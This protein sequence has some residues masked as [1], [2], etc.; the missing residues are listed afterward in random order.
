MPVINLADVVGLETGRIGIASA[1]HLVLLLHGFQHIPEDY[2]TRFIN[3]NKLADG[4]FPI[5]KILD[6]FKDQIPP[7]TR[8]ELNALVNKVIQLNPQAFNKDGSLKGGL[9]LSYISKLN[10]QA[11]VYPE[12]YEE[13]KQEKIKETD[14]TESLETSQQNLIGTNLAHDVLNTKLDKN[15]FRTNL[16]KI[17]KNNVAHFVTAFTAEWNK[18]RAQICEILF[19]YDKDNARSK[20][21]DILSKLLERAKE[22]GIP[23]KL[24]SSDIEKFKASKDPKVLDEC[25]MNIAVMVDQVSA[26]KKSKRSTFLKNL[27][28]NSNDVDSMLNRGRDTATEADT[29]LE[30]QLRSDGL[31]G[32]M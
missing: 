22:L 28:I 19:E 6:Q 7:I 5:D 30:Q 31:C 16:G 24:I 9:K 27:E 25:L 1:E 12:T 8:Q 10:I 15:S 18:S 2:R 21:D 3:S 17:N 29:M 20:A 32:W 13:V 4:K 14:S 26:Q 23:N 11:P